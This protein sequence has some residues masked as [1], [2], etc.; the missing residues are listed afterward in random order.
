MR[1]IPTQYLDGNFRCNSHSLK[2]IRHIVSCGVASDTFCTGDSDWN[3]EVLVFVEG[4][5]PENPEQGENQQQ[6]QPT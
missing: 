5:K 1:S 3:L 2:V 4:E 6:I